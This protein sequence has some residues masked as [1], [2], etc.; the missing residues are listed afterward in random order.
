MGTRVILNDVIGAYVNL[1]NARAMN[2]GETPKFSMSALIK[3]SDTQTLAI[4]QD[5]VAKEIK[6]KGW[7]ASTVYLPLQDGDGLTPKSRKA[8]PD[9]F[10]GCY[11]LPVSNKQAPG[12]VDAELRP[13]TDSSQ[14][15]FGDT[16][17]LSLDVYCY[18]NSSGRGVSFDLDNVMLVEK[19]APKRK[20]TPEE[21]FGVVKVKSESEAEDFLQ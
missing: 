14:V 17:R 7:D 13:I 16:F 5:A 2:K 10:H 12:V 6:K 21:D 19:A 3:K 11:V 20:R 18:E 4:I 15:T 1:H 9:D 8:Y